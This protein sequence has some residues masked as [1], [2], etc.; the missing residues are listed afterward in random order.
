[1]VLAGEA[2]VDGVDVLDEVDEQVRVR[3]QHLVV[4][5]GGKEPVPPAEGRVRVDD[6]V[7]VPLDLAEDVLE[8]RPAQGVESAQGQVEDPPGHNVGCLGVHHVADVAEQDVVAALGGD[9]DDLLEEGLLIDADLAGHDHAAAGQVRSS[10]EH[11]W[12][13][14]GCHMGADVIGGASELGNGGGASLVVRCQ[15]SVVSWQP[16]P[17]RWRPSPTSV[18]PTAQR[19]ADD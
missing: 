19:T 17:I 1:M 18:Q 7:A 12:C 9:A 13:A 14:Y 15:S 11:V 16:F 5:E 6:D 3:L 8:D 4:V 10:C 2:F